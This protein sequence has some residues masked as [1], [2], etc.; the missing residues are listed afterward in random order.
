MKQKV[1]ESLK[2]FENSIFWPVGGH[3][4]VFFEVENFC[5][6]F[7]QYPVFISGNPINFEYPT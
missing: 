6:Y 7:G 2:C 5:G 4:K 3:F 1:K